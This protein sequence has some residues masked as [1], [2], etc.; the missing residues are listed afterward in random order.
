MRVVKKADW[1]KRVAAW[2]AS[3][4]SLREFCEGRD[5]SPKRLQWWAWHLV[6]D[7]N[8]SYRQTTTILTAAGVRVVDG[9]G[10]RRPRGTGG[11]EGRKRDG[12][13]IPG[14]GGSIAWRIDEAGCGTSFASGD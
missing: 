3:G 2:R 8:Y 10:T 13:R 11:R 4:K 6:I 14:E 7:V 5:Y 1:A 12:S 9:C